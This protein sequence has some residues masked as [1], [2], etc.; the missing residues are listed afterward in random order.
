MPLDERDAG[1]L[2][3]MLAFAREAVDIRRGRDREAFDA[4]REFR[5]ATERMVELIGEAA[6]RVSPATRALHAG[7]AWA[8][9]VGTRSVIVHDY[10]R[11]EYD[12]VWTV[13]SED[14]PRLIAQLEPIVAALPP[15][16]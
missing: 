2:L 13:L 14:V 3:D 1:S 4:S 11:I 9:I 12:I 15:P 8:D 16:E 5:R 7:I 10:G 6:R